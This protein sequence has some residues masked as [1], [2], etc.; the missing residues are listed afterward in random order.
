MSRSRKP[1]VIYNPSKISRM[2]ELR[3]LVT[4]TARQAGLGEPVFVETAPDS[5]GTEQAAS[6]VAAGAELVLAAGGDGTVRA[7][8]AGMAG[9]DV[10][11]AIL[12]FGT[13]NLLGR[14]INVPPDDMQEAVD[15]A[16]FGM[17]TKID[18]AWMKVAGVDGELE[19]KPE[20]S[21]LND[22]HRAL[23][24]KRGAHVPDDDEYAFIVI[25]GQGWDA[26]IMSGTNSQ[27]KERVGWGAY[28]VSGAKALTAP[29]MRSFLTLDKNKK[30]V[31][32]GRSLLFANC[33]SLLI[34]VVLAPEAKLDDGLLDVASLETSN[35]ILGWLDLFTKIGA[36]GAGVKSDTL[37]G[38]AGRL[39]F[40]QATEAHSVVKDAHP[41]QLDG[42]FLGYAREMNVRVDKQALRIR[43]G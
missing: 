25:A 14:N 41:I 11:L 39:D 43:H 19:L 16:F 13:G 36:Q 34:G 27:L 4:I 1:Y 15:I 7:V 24:E 29:K 12:P 3:K 38:T 6:A 17:E 33:S 21:F 26:R 23:L 37:P 8:A 10:P 40:V 31:I 32:D 30:Y 20:G 18:I 28:V 35:G 22:A 9:T 5:L 42:D 2:H